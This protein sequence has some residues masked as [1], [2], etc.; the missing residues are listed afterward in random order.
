MRTR[1]FV[2]SR[3]DGDED[4]KRTMNPAIKHSSPRMRNPIMD[5]IPAPAVVDTPAAA[6]LQCEYPLVR[7]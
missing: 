2:L 7:M 6:L 3:S 5:P 4:R 1:S